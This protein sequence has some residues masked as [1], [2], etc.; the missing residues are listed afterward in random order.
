MKQLLA[1]ALVLVLAPA[2]FSQGIMKK[3]E[4]TSA[5]A[6]AP[7]T[8]APAAK[9]TAKAA[10]KQKGYSGTVCTLLGCAGGK[11]ATLSKAEAQKAAARGEVLCLCVGKKSYVVLNSDGTNASAKLADMAGAK[12]TVSGKMLTKGGASVIIADS[13]Q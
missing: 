8:P 6:P 1:L 9:T 10:A 3:K 12:V 13:M 5:A 7:A 2:A 4:A 11:C